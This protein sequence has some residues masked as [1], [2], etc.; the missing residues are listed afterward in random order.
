MGL[1]DL[2]FLKT[3][4]LHIDDT[5]NEIKRLRE[6]N[7]EEHKKIAN[8]KGDITRWG[9]QLLEYEK[10]VKKSEK[11]S[12]K[13]NDD[14]FPSFELEN[15]AQR[16]TERE[17][18]KCMASWKKHLKTYFG[19]R[20]SLPSNGLFFSYLLIP[21]AT[22][23]LSAVLID[24]LASP[25]IYDNTYYSAT[26]IILTSV[27]LSVI[28]THK[29]SGKIISRKLRKH[30]LLSLEAVFG[31]LDYF[32]TNK[33][34]HLRYSTLQKYGAYFVTKEKEPSIDTLDVA[35]FF[36][37]DP[38]TLNK[39]HMEKEFEALNR[40]L[41]PIILIPTADEKAR[42]K[43][44]D[45]HINSS[46]KLQLLFEKGE[47]AKSAIPEKNEQISKK[48]AMIEKRTSTVDSNNVRIKELQ[49][50]RKDLWASIS[51]LIPYSDL[52]N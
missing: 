52:I 50:D 48:K 42:K 36:S 11:S 41:A 23:L 19:D 51:H 20:H 3:T 21:L 31:D 13:L 14:A 5:D 32:N 39:Y 12:G 1:D 44:I 22:L 7:E 15:A 17:R 8:G 34:G 40:H 2:E 28:I 45:K 35:P 4:L 10:Q 25:F 9:N 46:K 43:A 6:E 47:E 49:K 33:I 24:N 16:K 27:I 30:R 18:E 26:I 37:D 29:V 38:S